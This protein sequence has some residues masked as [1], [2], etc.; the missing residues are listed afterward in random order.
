M[1]AKR[2]GA[3]GRRG[4]KEAWSE[5]KPAEECGGTAMGQEVPS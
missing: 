4:R 2:K 1:I 5:R 3:V